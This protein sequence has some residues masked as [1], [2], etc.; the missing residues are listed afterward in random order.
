M[1]VPLY[2]LFIYIHSFNNLFIYITALLSVFAA[3]A[4]PQP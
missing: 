2:I 1:H 3:T 4:S